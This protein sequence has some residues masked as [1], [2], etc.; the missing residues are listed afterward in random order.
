METKDLLLYGAIGFG[1]YM[2]LR[3]QP[4]YVP[5]KSPTQPTAPTGNQPYGPYG[6]NYGM[7][8][9]QPTAPTPPP[10][11][12]SWQSVLTGFGKGLGDL[13]GGLAKGDHAYTS[14]DSNYEPADAVYADGIPSN[15]PNEGWD[16]TAYE[17]A[18]SS[19]N[20]AGNFGPVMPPDMYTEES[21]GGT[22]DGF[23]W[24]NDSGYESGDDWGCEDC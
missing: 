3:K 23:F 19:F 11:D 8:A 12:N 7:G 10:P 15:D 16:N 22:G 18:Q 5:P 4:Q 20:D 1:A 9:P 6:P 13:F 2:L 24:G 14:P 17:E 21:A